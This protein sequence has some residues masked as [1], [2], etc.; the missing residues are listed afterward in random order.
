MN[1]LD[2]DSGPRAMRTVPTESPAGP[3]VTG[4]SPSLVEG[5]KRPPVETAAR[6][7]AQCVTGFTESGLPASPRKLGQGVEGR[8][9]GWV[10]P[11]S[12]EPEERRH[13]SH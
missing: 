11:L 6:V 2:R 13:A 4:T 10:G 3:D 1:F 5:R 12:V 7:H 9:R 8:K